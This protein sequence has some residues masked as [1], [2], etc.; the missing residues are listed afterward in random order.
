MYIPSLP[1]ADQWGF[2]ID[3]FQI[4]QKV[5]ILLDKSV[6]FIDPV[7]CPEIQTFSMHLL[8]KALYHIPWCTRQVPYTQGFTVRSSKNI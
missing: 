5:T 4:T 2:E 7:S 8:C 6:S 1:F 3:I